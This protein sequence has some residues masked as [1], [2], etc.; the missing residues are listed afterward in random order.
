MRKKKKDLDLSALEVPTPDFKQITL[1]QF[2]TLGRIANWANARDV[3]TIAKSIF[4]QLLRAGDMK[5][6]ITV[7]TEVH[8]R[9]VLDSMI[10]ERKQ[11]QGATKIRPSSLYIDMMAQ[12]QNFQAP[13]PPQTA[14]SSA[15]NTSEAET[16]QRLTKDVPPAAPANEIKRDSGVSDAV[17][18][19][20]QRDK[21]AAK[22]KE[23]QY[24]KLIKASADAAN[25][26]K[27]L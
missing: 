12:I 1:D 17:W 27:G 8:V 20:M 7:V 16:P 26:I 11:R 22:K 10:S 23:E 18:E 9:T 19:Q 5:K 2:N 21:Q 3:Q 13:P 25:N 6:A 14:A 15:M 24:Q 4:G